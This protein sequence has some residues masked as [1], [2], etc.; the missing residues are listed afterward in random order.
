MKELRKVYKDSGVDL[1]KADFLVNRIKE[2]SKT[3][4]TKG[5][6]SDI[7]LFGGMYKLD[8]QNI[9]QP[10]LI[11]SADGV[12]TK[13][14]IAFAINKHDTVGIDLVAMNVN[15]IVVHGAKPLFFLDYMAFGKLDVKIGEEVIKGV[16]EGCKQAECA[17]LGGETA[18]MPDFYPP[19]EYELSGF[20]VGIVDYEK[21]V[22]GSDISVGDVLIGLAS[23][24]VHSNGFS[25]IRKIIK[26]KKIDLN[27]KFSDSES[28]IGEVLLTPTK[29]YVKLV[30]NLLRNFH[31][32]GIVHITGGGFYDNIPR[33]L[34]RSVSVNINF[35]AW[36]K[37]EIF[38]WIKT[39]GNLN[40]EEMCQVFNCGIGMVLIVKKED[41]DDVINFIKAV[42]EDAWIIGE[43]IHWDM[44]SS[45]VKISF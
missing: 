17:L 31:I 28:S 27:S 9:S 26:D 22:D 34:P 15:D 43:V 25:L 40:W 41:V 19:G 30:L 44:K 7:G 13:L 5:V 35:N 32:K 36:P 16:V 20:C 14:K 11:S 12:G 6:L 8:L 38:N 42:K 23:S 29:I 37:P 18:E 4:H 10:V 45:H 1:D 39:E 2:L 21:I 24:G 33:I 3:T